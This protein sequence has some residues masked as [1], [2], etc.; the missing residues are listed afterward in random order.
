MESY[1]AHQHT[2]IKALLESRS[3]TESDES[4]RWLVPGGT[5]L[6]VAAWHRKPKAIELLLDLG[7]DID[8]KD[9]YGSTPLHIAARAGWT[10]GV[11]RLLQRAATPRKFDYMQ[12]TPFLTAAT[13]LNG[14]VKVMSLLATREPDRV[15]VDREGRT[16]LHHAAL[17]RKLEAFSYLLS[18]GWDPHQLDK[19]GRSP[20]HYALSHTQLASYI[21]AICLE[22]THLLPES[23]EIEGFMA[24][25]GKFGSRFFYRWFPETARLR[26]LNSPLSSGDT[27]LINSA[28][29]ADIDGMHIRIR[30]GA[31]LE[32]RSRDGDTA[33]IAACRR[34]RLL[35]VAYLVRQGSKLEYTHENQPISALEAASGFPDI[36]KWFLVDR[37]T[38]QIK[39]TDHAFNGNEHTPLRAWAGIR[40]AK[41]PLRGK[42]ER[43]EGSSLLDHAKYLHGVA[44]D[45]WRVMVPLGWDT[46]AHLVPLLGEL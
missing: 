4:N 21:Y 13:A 2:M 19:K 32:V 10:E 43:P 44:R 33:L 30:A 41:I 9:H 15:S 1:H 17:A 18:A 34:G 36:I 46:I 5:A 40:T 37:W 20:I 35:A 28:M 25:P 8:A 27:P 11:E 12:I 24:A 3:P 6:H 22:P 26:Y 16:A 23:G 42:F 39:L 14:G 7:A 45:G 38:D 31:D 29:Y